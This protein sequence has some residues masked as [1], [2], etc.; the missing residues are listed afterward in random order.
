MSLLRWFSRKPSREPSD[1][2]ASSGLRGEAGPLA[3][4]SSRGE[5][6]ARREHL[7]GVVRECMVNAGVLSSSY[8]FKVLS[9]DSRGRQFLVM[10]DLAGPLEGRVAQLPEVEASI[11][12]AAKARHG[13]VVKAVYWRRNE[14]VAVGT[15]A[16]AAAPGA[17]PTKLA[18]G[19]S[20]VSPNPPVGLAARRAAA[21]RDD[22]DPIDAEEVA[23]FKQAL[24]T[25]MARP[26]V[27]QHPPPSYTL[28]TGYEDTE[29]PDERRLPALST[30]QYGDL[31]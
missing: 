11:A 8:K 19:N 5:R 4:N 1:P 13:I 31:R 18:T 3:G 2:G 29:L 7:Y 28:L 10:V 17:T 16:K 9:L 14:H 21:K 24:A 22:F 30:S 6:A 26:A 15:P 23:A 20:A 25:G 27:P 12:Q